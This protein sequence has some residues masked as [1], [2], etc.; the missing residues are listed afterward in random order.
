MNTDSKDTPYQRDTHT[1]PTS[2]ETVSENL[3]TKLATKPTWKHTTLFEVMYRDMNKCTD[4]QVAAVGQW[5][6]RMH[7]Q[8]V[9]WHA[10]YAQAWSH[11]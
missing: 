9:C 3:E 11:F 2:L 1:L 8:A 10:Y 5:L 6:W 4:S 7:N